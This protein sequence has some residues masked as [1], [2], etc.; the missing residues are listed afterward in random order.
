MSR[1]SRSGMVTFVM[2][3]KNAEANPPDIPMCVLAHGYAHRNVAHADKDP[4]I[5]M[6][7]VKISFRPKY[8]PIAYSQ[9]EVITDGGAFTT[10][11]AKMTVTK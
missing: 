10:P 8:P 11:S 3:S 9:G 6:M 7:R 5:N 1:Y 4:F 2:T